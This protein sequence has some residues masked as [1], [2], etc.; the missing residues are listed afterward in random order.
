M[1]FSG[2]S[3]QAEEKL[4]SSSDKISNI[5]PFRSWKTSFCSRSTLSPVPFCFVSFRYVTFCTE[6]LH[7]GM[8]LCPQHDCVD[9]FFRPAA[10][11]LAPARVLCYNVAALSGCMLRW[12]KNETKRNGT[13]QSFNLVQPP[14]CMERNGMMLETFF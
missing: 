5:V 13:Q 6:L 12:L 10:W 2:I 7:M 11:L 9:Q 8:Y 1:I 14:F 4:Y 3:K